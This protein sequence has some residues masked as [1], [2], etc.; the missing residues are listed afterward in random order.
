MPNTF[1]PMAVLL[2]EVDFSDLLS[3]SNH[4]AGPAH[5]HKP[6]QVDRWSLRCND[7]LS[8]VAV[9]TAPQT[10]RAAVHFPG[11]EE[12]AL[13]G[14]CGG[15]LSLMGRVEQDRLIRYEDR[16][17]CS[18]RCQA[19]AG[20]LCDCQCGGANHQRTVVV[21]VRIDEGGVP[22]VTPRDVPKAERIA[23]EWRDAR[24]AV[25]AALVPEDSWLPRPTWERNQVIRRALGQ[26]RGK[27]SHAGRMRA[28]APAL[29]T[30][31]PA[32]PVEGRRP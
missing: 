2:G 30:I 16:S 14:A 17:A 18:S 26:A 25:R 9:E 3:A 15:M 10:G 27:T 28:L 19:A 23:K 24:A 12:A 5:F 20:P 22:R 11:S 29:A 6:P 21:T 7:C 1:N 13:C 31:M 8:V 32:Q 4:D